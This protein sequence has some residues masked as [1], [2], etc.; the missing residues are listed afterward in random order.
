MEDTFGS[1]GALARALT[2][3]EPRAEQA[4]LAAAVDFALSTGDHLVAEAGTGTGESLTYLISTR[5]VAG[6]G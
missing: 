3:F 1:G 5:C 4:A 2:G 6:G